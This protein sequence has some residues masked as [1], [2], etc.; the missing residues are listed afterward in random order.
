MTLMM[1]P[2]VIILILLEKYPDM[3]IMTPSIILT[4]E[5]IKP[6]TIFDGKIIVPWIQE[7]FHIIAELSRID[8]RNRQSQKSRNFYC[9]I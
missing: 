1:H 6:S 4:K 9:K 2:N 7:N 3:T 8:V 5:L